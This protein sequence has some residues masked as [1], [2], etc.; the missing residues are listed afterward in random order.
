MTERLA[1]DQRADRVW[2]RGWHEHEQRQLE[3]LAVLSLAE[4]LSWLEEAQRL[5]VHLRLRSSPAPE[6]DPFKST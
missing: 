5:L 6:Q 3:R 4:K 1:S 2:E